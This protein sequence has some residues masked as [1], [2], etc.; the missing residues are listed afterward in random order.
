MKMLLFY[1]LSLII[2]ILFAVLFSAMTWG[3]LKGIYYRCLERTKYFIL[4]AVLGF[5]FIWMWAILMV[6]GIVGIKFLFLIDLTK[7]LWLEFT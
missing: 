6:I 1:R 2:F 4:Q 5:I 7:G 3:L